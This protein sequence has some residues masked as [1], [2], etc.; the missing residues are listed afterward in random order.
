[1]GL[2]IIEQ[3]DEASLRDITLDHFASEGWH[4]VYTYSFSSASLD[5]KIRLENMEDAIGIRNAFNEEYT[6]MRRSL[7]PRLLMAATENLKYAESFGFF[8]KM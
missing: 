8:E 5:K 1:M 7:A 4:E 3:N 2:S 6:H